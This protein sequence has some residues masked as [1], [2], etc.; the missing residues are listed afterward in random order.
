M[1]LLGVAVGRTGVWA[2]AQPEASVRSLSPAG[3]PLVDDEP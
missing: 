3:G 1:G 2:P